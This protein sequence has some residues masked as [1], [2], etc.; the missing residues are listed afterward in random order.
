M[1]RLKNLLR[2]ALYGPIIFI[3]ACYFNPLPTQTVDEPVKPYLNEFISLGNEICPAKI[4]EHP[5]YTIHIEPLAPE[6]AGVCTRLYF[7]FT[8]SFNSLHWNKYSEDDKYQLIAHEASHCFF[9][10]NHSD[11]PYNYMYYAM[12]NL[13]KPLVIEQV[14]KNMRLH[15]GDK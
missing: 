11:D 9:G 6:I 14:K 1:S 12:N 3:Y 2:I 7:R 10:I 5:T 13:T 4:A 8:I 15:C